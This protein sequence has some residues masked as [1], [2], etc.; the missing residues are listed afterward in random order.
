MHFTYECVCVYIFHPLMLVCV[1]FPTPSSS[2]DM[3]PNQQWPRLIKAFCSA[4]GAKSGASECVCMCVCLP[5]QTEK[6]MFS[7]GWGYLQ[8][9]HS[10]LLLLMQN[11]AREQRRGQ[12]QKWG[13]DSIVGKRKNGKYLPLKEKKRK[14]WNGKWGRFQQKVTGIKTGVVTGKM[15]SRGCNERVKHWT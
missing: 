15:E 12:E 10:S 3:R 9:F 4:T 11:W 8:S 7:P 1:C 14:S 5:F 6:P 2:Y 13:F